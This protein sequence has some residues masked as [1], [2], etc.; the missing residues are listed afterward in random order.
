MLRN[1]ESGV[2]RRNDDA[3]GWEVFFLRHG[4]TDY[5]ARGIFQGSTDAPLN[6]KGQGQAREAARL[7]AE[8]KL[9]III[10]STLQRARQTA[11]VVA[12][13]Q[14]S[15]VRLELEPGLREVDFG[16]WEGLTHSQA[17]SRYPR[18]MA[19]LMADPMSG[20]PAGMERLAQMED[21]AR[22][23][24]ES[25][26]RAFFG[27]PLALVAHGGTLTALLAHWSGSS[28]LEVWTHVAL[29]NGGVNRALFRSAGPALEIPWGS[30]LEIQLPD[31]VSPD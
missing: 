20:G 8:T 4:E 16:P 22:S 12:G 27:R 30:P 23:A 25:I 24:W 18:E 19:A 28:Y 1:E 9:E 7:L 15:P 5:N 21:R 11:T 13:H 29:L 31:R 17:K 6:V 3:G 10:S 26:R 14:G 2:A